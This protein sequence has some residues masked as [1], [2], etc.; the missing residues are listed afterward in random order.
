MFDRWLPRQLCCSATQGITSGYDID[1]KDTTQAFVPKES[2]MHVFDFSTC[3]QIG[4]SSVL[5]M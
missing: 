1:K 4:P 3:M 5:Q 2:S